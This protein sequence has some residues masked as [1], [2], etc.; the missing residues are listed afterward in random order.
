[1]N[2]LSNTASEFPFQYVLGTVESVFCGLLVE[3]DATVAS[4]ANNAEQG[5]IAPMDVF[6]D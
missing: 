3:H 5:A 1:M 4:I 6:E 2:S